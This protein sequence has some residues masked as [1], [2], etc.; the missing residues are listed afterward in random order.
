[1]LKYISILLILPWLNFFALPKKSIKVMTYNIHHANPPGSPGLINIDTLVKIINREQP[2]LLALQEV[3]KGVKRS[4]EMDQ[5]LAI[6]HRTGM[7]YR[8]FKAIDYDGGEYGVAILSKLPI[9]KANHI[10]LPQSVK[11]EARVMGYVELE[12]S[13]KERLIFANTHLDARRTDENR[14][15]QMRQIMDYFK[16]SPWPVILA[17]DF[18]DV[19]R[20]N[21]LDI[22]DQDFYRAG[23]EISSEHFGLTFPQ[24]NPDRTLD[25][26]GVKHPAASAKKTSFYQMTEFSIFPESYASDHLPVMVKYRIR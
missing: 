23:K 13:K 17:G 5:A 16:D 15:L 21:T 4:G 6:A 12:M 22:F 14:Q 11:A 25:Y 19:P 2:D 18:N 24:D 8:F 1:M 3:D 7:H 10:A 20:S 26:I 9:L